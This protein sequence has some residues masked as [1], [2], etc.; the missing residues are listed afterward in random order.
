[1]SKSTLRNDEI[2]HFEGKNPAGS[3]RVINN[4]FTEESDAP[5]PILQSNLISKAPPGAMPLHTFEEQ[6]KLK[7]FIYR[8]FKF[9]RK[10]T[11][12]IIIVAQS[13]QIS[14]EGMMVQIGN[15]IT[16]IQK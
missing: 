14:L 3:C 1:M 5:P 15:V 6:S 10:Y 8:F 12:N 4:S 2:H 11:Y 16:L 9:N 13:S 7:R